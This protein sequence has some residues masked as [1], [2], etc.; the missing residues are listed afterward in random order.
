[1]RSIFFVSIIFLSMNILSSIL[2][3]F[4]FLRFFF[5]YTMIQCVYLFFRSQEDSSLNK[6]CFFLFFFVLDIYFSFYLGSFFL[7]A[8]LLYF[9]RSFP[10]SFL[11]SFGSRFS[12]LFFVSL[13]FSSYVCVV[14]FICY[15][16]FFWPFYNII[17]FFLSSL[18]GAFIWNHIEKY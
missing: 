11:R 3:T 9:L 6:F 10:S 14:N 17:S 16:F 7:Y 4:A 5:I 18:L 15:S 12:L 1:M 13:T 2:V 8:L